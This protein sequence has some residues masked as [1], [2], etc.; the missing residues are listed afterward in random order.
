MPIRVFAKD[1]ATLPAAHNITFPRGDDGSM[2]H[3][4]MYT[5]IVSPVIA[6]IISMIYI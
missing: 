5:I 4:P 3:P 1:L 2:E 6:I